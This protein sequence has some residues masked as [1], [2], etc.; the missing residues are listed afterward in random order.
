MRKALSLAICLGVL[1][2]GAWADSNYRYI[3]SW[4]TDMYFGHVIYPKAEH[5][6]EDTLVYREGQTRPEVADLNLPI[7]PGDTIKT[8]GR[9]CEIQFDT[10]TIIRL[11]RDTELKV[12]TILAQSLSSKSQLTN[13]LL[14]KGQIYLMYKRY[15]RKEIFQVIT[16]NAALKLDHKSVA[17]VHAKSVGV[18][19]FLLKEGKVSVLYGPDANSIKSKTVKKPGMVTITE[20]YKLATGQ[21]QVQDDF[22]EWNKKINEKFMELHE[23]KAALPLPI[24]K[25]SRAV[26][27]FAQ[28]YSTLYGEWLWDSCFGYVWRPFLN[29]RSYPGY[30]G[31]GWMPYVYGRWTS[32]Q[33]QLFWVPGETWGWVPSHLGFWMWN[34][35]KGWLWIPGSVFAPAWVDWSF[36]SGYCC[37]R[38]WSYL[39]WYEYG[40]GVLP[41]FEYFAYLDREWSLEPPPSNYESTPVRQVITKDQLKSKKPPF[42]MPKEAK[43]TYKKVMLA[44]KN[45]EDWARSLLMESPNQVVMVNPEDLNSLTIQKKIVNLAGLSPEKKIEFL[46]DNS[47]QE[48]YRMASEIF[49][50]NEKVAA[51]QV[52]ID[53]MLKDL[54]RNELPQIQVE[55]DAFVQD[56]KIKKGEQ[57]AVP[58]PKVEIDPSARRRGNIQ[59]GTIW[60]GSPNLVK[61]VVPVQ[62]KAELIQTRVL[63]WNPDVKIARRVGVTIRYSSRSNEVRCPDLHLSSRHVTGSFGYEGPRVRLTTRGPVSASGAIETSFGSSGASGSSTSSSASTSSTSGGGAKS[64]GS[65]GKAGKI[66]K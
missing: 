18:T 37:W 28:K 20:G 52:K 50:R 31:R 16:P 13:L 29:D 11:D 5:D 47:Q 15:V 65:S 6:G 41:H 61:N 21:D 60:D 35:N 4:D 34:K 45:G 42:P 8:L 27:N 24:Q 17:V 12:Q 40:W 7:A 62:S 38:P 66:K 43:A 19:D 63:D 46:L 3:Y 56:D 10:G 49:T 33:G 14:F 44:L 64:S 32:V 51:L 22:E 54:K 39:D 26:Y 57:T 36:C 30:P 59:Q 1:V 23:G 58:S 25:L 2:V 53:D 55:D 48:P 9:R